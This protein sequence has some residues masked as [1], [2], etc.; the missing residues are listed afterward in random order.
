MR[1]KDEKPTRK[2]ACREQGIGLRHKLGAVGLD[3]LCRLA[4]AAADIGQDVV[5][6][7]RLEEQRHVS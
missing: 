1:K 3:V 7:Q 5:P 2:P 4:A 6:E